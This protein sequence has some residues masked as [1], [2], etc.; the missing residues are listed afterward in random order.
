MNYYFANNNS[1][2]LNEISIWKGKDNEPLSIS[3]SKRN[4]TKISTLQTRTE[5]IPQVWLSAKEEK[6]SPVDWLHPE[7]GNGLNRVTGAVR[8]QNQ[9]IKTA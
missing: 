6:A 5:D 8:S 4:N 7:W 3:E 2:L 9:Y 1:Y